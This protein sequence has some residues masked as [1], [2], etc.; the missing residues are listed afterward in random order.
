MRLSH[1][2][3][4]VCFVVMAVLAAGCPGPDY[5]KCDNDGQCKK[6]KDGAEVNEYCL[7]GQCQ[8]CAKDTHCDA[9]ERCNRGRCEQTC[10]SDDQCGTGNICESSRCVKAQC[11]NDDQ[12]GAGASCETGRCRRAETAGTTGTSG[13]PGDGELNCQMTGLVNFDFNVADLRPEAR[14]TLD[15]MAKCMQKNTTWKLTIAGHADERGTPEYNLSLGESR[16]KSAR[17]YL[18]ALGVAESRIKV[19]SYGEE[20]PLNPGSSEAAWA[21]NRRA[22]LNVTP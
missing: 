10:A 5:P 4:S 19:V 8:E 1:V 6:N 2:F 20:K 13:T 11:E 9:G 16:A 12:C 22:E 18:S 15:T 21:E 7:L 14:S 3:L 17:K